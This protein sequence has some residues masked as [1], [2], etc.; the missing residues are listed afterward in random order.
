[1][2]PAFPRPL[3]A[4]VLAAAVLAAPAPARAQ[5]GD[6]LAISATWSANVQRLHSIGADTLG[7]SYHRAYSPGVRMDLRAIDLPMG[8]GAKP[9]LHLSASVSEDEQVLGPPVP[10]MDVAVFKTLDFG[11]GVALELPLDALVKGNPGVG[12]RLGWEGSYVLTRTGGQNF[13]ERSKLRLDF[14][15]TTGALQGSSIGAGMGRDETFG[16]DACSGRWDVRV[17]L[18]A[19]L[20]AAP[21]ARPAAPAIA[22]GGKPAPPAVRAPNDTRLMWLFVDADVDTDG[23]PGADGLRGRA[24][25]GVDL[26]A[27]TTALLTPLR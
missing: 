4:L 7:L 26:N 18:Q 17:A 6:R 24:G 2:R 3:T 19:R 13:L 12:L 21:M 15:R 8:K 5:A 25:I 9:A 14:L 11:T 20:F 23:G 1:M 16:W 10:G 27:F 22:P